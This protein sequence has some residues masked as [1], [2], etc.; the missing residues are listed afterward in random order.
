MRIVRIAALAALA[1]LSAVG[2]GR[3]AEATYKIDFVMHDSADA[4]AKATR[5]YTLFS[6]PGA[7]VALKLGSREPVQSSSGQYTYVDT[8]VNIECSLRPA[9]DEKIQLTADLDL[10]G[11]V[12]PDKAALNN[13]AN[14]TIAQL[15]LSMNALLTSGKPLVVGSIDD[16]VTSR[17]FEVE[18]T[19]TRIGQ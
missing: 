9:S 19:V 15:K 17:R 3:P 7:K 18:A 4:S 8:G 16:P 11:I 5:H 12:Q 13:S 10:S 1:A 2:Q 6:T 14:P